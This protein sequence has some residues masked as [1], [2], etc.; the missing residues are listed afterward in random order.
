MLILIHHRNGEIE[1]AQEIIITART[2][3]LRRLKKIRSSLQM[4]R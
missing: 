1:D 3:C 4:D 2:K